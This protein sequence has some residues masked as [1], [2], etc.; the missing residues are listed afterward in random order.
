MS[1]RQP[2]P[3]AYS[4]EGM[5]YPSDVLADIVAQRYARKYGRDIAVK[6]VDTDAV[7]YYIDQTG[8]RHKV[9]A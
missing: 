8:K 2:T 6:C 5:R 9:S 7:L 1:K 4:V 3:T